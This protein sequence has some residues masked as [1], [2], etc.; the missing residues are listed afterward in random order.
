MPELL[1]DLVPLGV[2]AMRLRLNREQLLRRIQQGRIAG[3]QEYGRWY[4]ERNALEAAEEEQG[5]GLHAAVRQKLDRIASG[6]LSPLEVAAED[7]QSR[8]A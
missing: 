6:D 5:R 7:E 4:V 2:A 8:R 3:R 1:T